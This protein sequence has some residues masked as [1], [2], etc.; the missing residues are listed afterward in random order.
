MNIEE[1]REYCITKKRTTEDFPFDNDTLVF[2]V[3]GKMFIMI[4]LDR[5]E[6]GKEVS[7]LKLDPEWASELID[8]YDGILGGFQM[9][10]S[11]DAKYVFEKHWNTVENHKDIS[12]EFLRELIDHSYEA[13][14]KKFTKKMKAEFNKL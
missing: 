9:G 12:S 14:V 10:R 13:V 11:P 6:K 3:M 1:L 8:S 2:K 7:V 5:W 4:P